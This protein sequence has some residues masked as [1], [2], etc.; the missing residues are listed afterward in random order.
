MDFPKMMCPT[1]LFVI[2]DEMVLQFPCKKVLNFTA[3]FR[4][5]RTCIFRG[6]FYRF[7]WTSDWNSK[8]PKSPPLRRPLKHGKVPCLIILPPFSWSA[9]F[10]ILSE[11]FPFFREISFGMP[12]GKAHKASPN[13]WR[14]SY[15]YNDFRC[16]LVPYIRR[17]FFAPFFPSLRW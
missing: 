14:W 17:R 9:Y 12:S 7:F 1:F 16:T 5:S 3:F 11:T 2:L 6:I 8:Y 13:H 15:P 4:G 10:C